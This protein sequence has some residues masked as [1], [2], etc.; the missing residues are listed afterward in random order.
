[1]WPL[2]LAV[3][4]PPTGH[5]V[6]A[7]SVLWGA[8]VSVALWGAKGQLRLS[9]KRADELKAERDAERKE[10]DRV[11]AEH[12][13]DLVKLTI[14]ADGLMQIRNELLEKKRRRITGESQT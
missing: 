12:V 14:A 6:T 3:D 10:A 1:M 8:L 2:L 13:R 9:E 11:R 7:I 5:L 4:V